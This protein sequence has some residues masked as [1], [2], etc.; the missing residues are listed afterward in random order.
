MRGAEC[1]P[2][3]IFL[4]SVPQMPQVCTLRRSSPAPIRGTGTVSTRTSPTPRYTAACMVV[5]IAL[6]CF[7]VKSPLAIPRYSISLCTCRQPLAKRLRSDGTIPRQLSYSGPQPRT[8]YHVRQEA[9]RLKC[10]IRSHKAS[11]RRQPLIARIGNHLAGSELNP[12]RLSATRNSRRLHV[13]YI[14][15]VSP[16]QSRFLLRVG[17]C[18]KAHQYAFAGAR[19]GT[20]AVAR[21]N[22]QAWSQ[23][24]A[25]SEGW[26]KATSKPRRNNQRGFI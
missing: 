18:G 22:H 10:P 1:D 20:A 9:E 26:V 13:H 12:M 4:R 8:Q 23:R 25:G 19:V 6:V 5:G 7:G 2:V 16:G 24:V 17:N 14:G 21:V 15:P 3:A 11:D